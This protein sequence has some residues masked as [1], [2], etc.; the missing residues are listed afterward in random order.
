MKWN[1]P[2]SRMIDYQHLLTPFA[3]E[4]IRG[5]ENQLEVDMCT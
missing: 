3:I 1:N 2:L 4:R 5:S